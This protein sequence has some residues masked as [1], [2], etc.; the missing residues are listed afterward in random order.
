LV[1]DLNNELFIGPNLNIQQNID[2]VGGGGAVRG[3]MFGIN[4]ING[5]LRDSGLTLDNGIF[6]EGPEIVNIG[7]ILENRPPPTESIFC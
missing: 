3:G 1:F 7:N 2:S 6:L 4:T 5:G